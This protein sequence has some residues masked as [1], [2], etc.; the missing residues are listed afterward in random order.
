MHQDELGPTDTPWCVWRARTGGGRNA[1]HQSMKP[2]LRTKNRFDHLLDECPNGFLN[3]MPAFCTL[4]WMVMVPSP[5]DSMK[6]A[7]R[8]MV[9]EMSAEGMWRRGGRS[10]ECVGGGCSSPSGVGSKEGVGGATLSAFSDIRREPQ[11]S[12]LQRLASNI[13]AAWQVG[14]PRSPRLRASLCASRSTECL[15]AIGTVLL[16][17]QLNHVHAFVWTCVLKCLPSIL[18]EK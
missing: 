14:N 18:S 11:L 5:S 13:K 2:S 6:E 8:D 9:G 1:T 3:S 15:G 7:G 16:R 10:T 4:V 17:R 12:A